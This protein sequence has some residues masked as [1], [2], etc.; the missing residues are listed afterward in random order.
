MSLS[1]SVDVAILANDPSKDPVVGVDCGASGGLTVF[2]VGR[3][4]CTSGG[5]RSYSVDGFT[6]SYKLYLRETVLMSSI[7]GS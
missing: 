6:W 5:T 1:C 3:I 4:G 7:H 2:G